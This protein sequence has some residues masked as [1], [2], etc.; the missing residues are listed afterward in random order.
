MLGSQE[1][2]GGGWRL[3]LV[4]VGHGL[5]GS[6]AQRKNKFSILMARIK[7]VPAGRGLSS[8]KTLFFF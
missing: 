7:L 8:D 6:C 5:L 4:A 2:G 3:L 1:A